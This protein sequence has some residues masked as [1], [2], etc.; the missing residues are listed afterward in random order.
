M[1]QKTILILGGT[2]FVGS[3]LAA[4]LD[5]AGYTVRI[6]TRARERHRALL[7]LPNVELVEADVFA[8]GVLEQQLAGCAA[9]INLVGILNETRRQ[10]FERAHVALAERLCA[11]CRAAGITRLLHMSALNADAQGGASRYLRSKGAAEDLAHASGLDVTSLRPSVIFGAGDSFFN[12]FAALLRL[13]PV[14]PLACPAARFAPIHVGDVAECFARALTLPATI[15]QRYDLCGPCVYTLLELVR[16]TARVAGLRRLIL[17]LPDWAS[18][19]QARVL[20]WAPGKPFTRDNYRSLQVDAVCHAP[21]PEVFGLTPTP[22]ESVV[23]GYLGAGDDR[24]RV[25]AYL[26]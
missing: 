13:S 18:R 19:G 26:R 22:L 8:P 15:G 16:Y 20:E 12:R 3:R 24:S 25:R 6:I 5:R 7:V 14:L 11:A 23:P 9:A 1:A 4:R 17:P 10:G 21:F 2:G